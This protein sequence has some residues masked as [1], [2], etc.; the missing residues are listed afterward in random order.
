M[1]PKTLRK[2]MAIVVALIG[3]AVPAAAH[4]DAPDTVSRRRTRMWHRQPA[5]R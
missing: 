1:E 4:A 3:V 2:F 5:P